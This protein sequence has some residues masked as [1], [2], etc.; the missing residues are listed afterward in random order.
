M[1]RNP[2]VHVR[3][4]SSSP[5]WQPEISQ[6]IFGWALSHSCNTYSYKYYWYSFHAQFH[7]CWFFG[8]LEDT[9]P[10]HSLNGS[11]ERASWTEFIVLLWIFPPFRKLSSVSHLSLFFRE[12]HY[13]SH[14]LV[15]GAIFQWSSHVTASQ[16]IATGTLLKRQR[17]PTRCKWGKFILCPSHFTVLQTSL[18]KQT[19]IS[20]YSFTSPFAHSYTHTSTYIYWYTCNV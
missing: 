5:P 6:N 8:C 9:D 18:L 15:F 4:R 10:F 3:S 11:P 17:K 14:R 20:L 2:K 13:S 19:K 12:F 16:I 1:I 7:Q